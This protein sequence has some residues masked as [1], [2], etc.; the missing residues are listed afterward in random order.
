MFWKKRK[1]KVTPGIVTPLPEKVSTNPGSKINYR[2]GTPP[3][4]YPKRVEPEMSSDDGLL[5]TIVT[6]EVV[7]SV[8]DSSAFDS[9]S[10]VDSSPSADFTSGGD[11]GGGGASG[12]W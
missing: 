1:P 4:A 2:Q 10:S 12:D 9:S 7:E 5:N 8:F 11:S 3:P 6:A